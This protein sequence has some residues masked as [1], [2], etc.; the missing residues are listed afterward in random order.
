MIRFE[1]EKSFYFFILNLRITTV[2]V[3]FHKHIIFRNHCGIIK[4]RIYIHT[5][6]KLSLLYK[7]SLTSLFSVCAFWIWFQVFSF[8][9]VVLQFEFTWKLNFKLY[10]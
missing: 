2:K 6:Q 1:G 7:L 10:L 9:V 4:V 8:T 5:F 3:I